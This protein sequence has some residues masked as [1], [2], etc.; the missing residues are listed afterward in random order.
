MKIL[1]PYRRN[2][3]RQVISIFVLFLAFLL[4]ASQG[5]AIHSPAPV[6][7]EKS[8]DSNSE[9]G[10]KSDET[11]LLISASYSLSG[12]QVQFDHF[13]RIILSIPDLISSYNQVFCHF[14][15]FFNSYFNTL[16]HFIIATKAP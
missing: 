6:K 3:P 14:T 1:S 16:F 13:C 10:K 4:I 11:V 7:T 5:A 15:G 2:F 12:F 9:D 8:A